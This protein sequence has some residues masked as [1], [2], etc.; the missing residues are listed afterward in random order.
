MTTKQRNLQS[1]AAERKA[2]KQAAHRAMMA[3]QTARRAAIAIFD[4]AW[5]AW[6]E[7]GKI[8][9]EPLDPRYYDM[10]LFPENKVAA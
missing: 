8:G 5:T 9:P 7:G 1:A 10:A 3:R 6:Y 4:A 2:A